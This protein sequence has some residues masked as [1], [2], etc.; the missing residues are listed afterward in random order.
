MWAG[1]LGIELTT[2]QTQSVYHPPTPSFLFNFL[3]FSDGE[4]ITHSSRLQNEKQIHEDGFIEIAQP[5]A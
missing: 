3:V 2:R 4:N 5:P 1:T